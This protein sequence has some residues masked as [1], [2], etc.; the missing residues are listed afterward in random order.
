MPA[1]GRKAE[2]LA[3]VV[4]RVDLFRACP[5]FNGELQLSDVGGDAGSRTDV[6][7]VDGSRTDA[8]GDAGRRT[9]VGVDLY[10]LMYL[11]YFE[12]KNEKN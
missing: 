8:G 3:V 10:V 5:V 1:A 9:E 6:G 2:A 11:K 12:L 4:F 7:G